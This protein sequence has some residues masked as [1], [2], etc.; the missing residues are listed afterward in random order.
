MNKSRKRVI[1][2]D[3]GGIDRTEQ[4]V[5]LDALKEKVKKKYEGMPVTTLYWSVGDHE[6]YSYETKIGEVFGEGYE[7]IEE[8]AKGLDDF[9]PMVPGE[10]RQ[11][12]ESIRYL[13]DAFGGPLTLLVTLCREAGIELFPQVRMN[14][15]YS[16]G[17]SSPGYGRFRREHPEYLLG[18]PGEVIPEG[19]TLFGLT[20]GLDFAHVEVREHYAAIATEIVERFDV[21]GLD[22]DFM[23][24]PAFFRPWDAY[25]NRHLMTE[26]VR[27]VRGR[28]NEV[29]EARGRP[30]ELSVRVP[31]SLSD[32]ARIGLDVGEWMSQGLVD[33]VVA[34]GGFIPFDMPFEE[35]VEH[36]RANDV[37]IYGTLEVLRPAYESDVIRAVAS[38]YWSAGA[39]GIVFTNFFPDYLHGQDEAWQK[40]I[41]SEIAD[42]YRLRRLHKRYQMDR[43]D[44]NQP[45]GAGHGAAFKYAAPPA[46]LPVTLTQMPSGPR[47]TLRLKVFDVVDS[48]SADGEAARGT[49]RFGLENYAPE[50]ELEVRL[51]GE[52][53]PSDS[54]RA[55]FGAWRDLEWPWYGKRM[56]EPG[57]GGV[58]EFDVGCPPLRQGENE[59]EVRLMKHASGEAGPVV[60]R[61]VEV[62]VR[63]GANA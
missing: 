53:L 36:A 14:S 29:G 31:P 39:S 33:I 62:D 10:W 60:I 15:H 61:Y 56:T 3:D 51:N 44:R 46:Q 43:G 28:M 49:L 57:T 12:S 37:E 21:D 20:K 45:T 42:P 40:Q 9:P 26:V 55:S 2:I 13:N 27:Q 22:L 38:R 4:R 41:L 6:V 19:R 52:A 58:L 1:L 35:F 54:R 30:L 24:H 23:R 16:K 32:S 11:H 7:D 48:S 18:P 17:E 63:Y 50:S 25:A 47:A 8:A 34:G 5:S 59:L